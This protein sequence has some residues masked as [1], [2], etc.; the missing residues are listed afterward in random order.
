L[1]QAYHVKAGLHTA[2][3]STLGRRK[4]KKEMKRRVAIMSEVERV[5]A[6]GT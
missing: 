5:A 6:V 1:A 3:A 4:R 2:E